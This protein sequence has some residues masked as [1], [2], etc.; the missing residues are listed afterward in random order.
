[1]SRPSPPRPLPRLLHR[2]GRRLGDLPLG[3]R[4]TLLLLA[5]GLT[6]LVFSL[7]V[8]LRAFHQQISSNHFDAAERV[9]DAKVEEVQA[10][11]TSKAVQLDELVQAARGSRATLQENWSE[12]AGSLGFEDLLLVDT[13]GRRVVAS[14]LHPPMVG[15]SLDHD[16]LRRSGLPRVVRNLRPWH[17]VSVAPLNPDPGL[18][19][20]SSWLAVPF[21][22]SP[23][24]ASRLVLVGRLGVPAFRELFDSRVQ[25][26]DHQARVQLVLEER[27]GGSLRWQPLTL[28]ARAPA[29]SVLVPVL[30]A[31]PGLPGERTSRGDGGSGYLRNGR[32]QLLLAAWRQIPSSEVVVLAT[33]AEQELRQDS[34]ALTA[35]L[36]A[37]LAGTAVLVSGAGVL[38]GRR[39][40]A[41]IQRLHQAI[42]GFDPENESSLHPVEVQGHD[43]IAT[44]ART[45]NAMTR[46]IQERTSHLRATKEQLDTYIQTVQ[47]TLLALDR[48]GRVHLLNRSGCALLGIPPQG[49]HGI[50]WL[51]EWV[52]PGI[53]NGCGTGWR[54][55]GSGG[56]RPRASSSTGCARWP[57][58]PDGCAGI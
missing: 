37:L 10:L 22:T 18:G 39:L 23:S 33:I 13:Q 12:R 50:D 53:G 40:S 27:R 44:L 8:A 57:G 14:A 48:S 32:G 9:A 46:R 51:N 1:M 28:V 7:L 56:S 42:L 5:V 52:D 15:R 29:A 17:E 11:L 19:G 54:R 21:T 24:P 6:P 30:A 36:L 31:W 38:L 2:C 20:L 58:A 25:R 34:Q 41:P 16:P 35:Q 3:R 45:I 49:W 4:L 26:L 43:E 55:P 47:T